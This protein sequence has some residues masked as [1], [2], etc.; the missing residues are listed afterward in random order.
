MNSAATQTPVPSRDPA[1]GAT[2]GELVV[3]SAVTVFITWLWL[4]FARMGV[5]MHHDGIMLKPALDVLNG[6]VL[7]RD[8]FS[9]YGPLTTLIQVIGLWVS[10]TLLMLKMMS[11]AAMTTALFFF[12]AA[13]REVLPRALAV[14]AAVLAGVL[15]PFF[16]PGWI[17]M[18]WSSDYAMLFQ[19]VALFALLK[20]LFT[21]D[22]RWGWLCGVAMAA[23][24]WCRQPVGLTLI[25]AAGFTLVAAV[26]T[27]WRAPGERGTWRVFGGVTGGVLAVSAL[28]V[29]GMALNGAL[30]YWWEQNIAWPRRWAD[31]AIRG[32][33]LLEGQ[34]GD[35]TLNP[36]AVLALVVG[37]VTTLAPW[38]AGRI[39][40]REPSGKVVAIYWAV[41]L[42]AA[43]VGWWSW[44]AW[45]IVPGAGWSLLAPAVIVAMCL[46]VVVQAVIARIK[47]VRPGVVFF[48]TAALA[49]L[50]LASLAQYY[51]VPC[52]RHVFWAL[53]MGCGI[54]VLA[55]WKW[56]RVP[57]WAVAAGLGLLLT[58]AVLENRGWAGYVLREPG[59]VLERPAVLAGIKMGALEADFCMWLD[60]VHAEIERMAPGRGV[61]LF[62]DDA[63]LV[64][65]ARTL[66][67]PGPYHVS[68]FP[69]MPPEEQR[70][71]WSWILE[72]RPA[73]L[74]HIKTTNPVASFAENEGYYSAAGYAAARVEVFVPV[75]WRG[76][77]SLPTR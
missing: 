8:T 61:A 29:G 2:R 17:V 3:A 58:P 76:K 9:Q 25:I 35:L 68:W 65:P 36:R 6:Q 5:D 12:Y 46:V 71:R 45:F 73:L 28:M 30:P 52:P 32:F 31:P 53:A 39:I 66:R 27:G 54:F 11:V 59:V 24:F 51:P 62:G 44:R 41:L 20:A 14:V 21:G 77:I 34:F 19:A 40:G 47:G 1:L 64:V 70:F 26:A 49:G 60:D 13:W 23:T 72:N 55:L 75:E 56:T 33:N 63:F 50:S 37:L 22:G 15:V 48:Q 74:V 67:N 16:H 69:A 18:P 57:V 43:W 7:F 10:P 42:V 4:P 38:L